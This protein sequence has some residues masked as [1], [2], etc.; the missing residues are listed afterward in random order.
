MRPPEYLR[1]SNGN[2]EA[3]RAIVTE[4]RA[5][6]NMALV[7]DSVLNWPNKFIATA[8]TVDGTTGIMDK[9]T[10]TV[11]YGH[12]AGSIIMIEEFA[13]GYSDLGNVENQ[14]VVLKPSTPWADAVAATVESVGEAVAAAEA[15]IADAI[16]SA[17]TATTAANTAA[18]AA[19]TAA[20]DANTAKT[21]ANTA[22]SA[23]NTAKT[24]A[25]TATTNANTAAAAANTAAGSV[26]TAITNANTAT[27]NANNAATA[28]NTAVNNMFLA[29][30]PVG[31]IFMTVTATNPGT[32][33]GGTWTAFG[34]GRVPVG[35]DT[36]QTEFNTV[37]K[38]GGAKTHT[39]TVNEMPAHNHGV[40]VNQS[41]GGAYAAASYTWGT[42][43]QGFE[44]AGTSNTGGGLAHNNLQPYI[45]C[46]MWKRTA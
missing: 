36:T 19:S 12:R 29:A 46:Y 18:S 35:V 28:A 43:Y 34:A 21:A 2:G 4:D 30:H 22:A 3:V 20:T 14:I 26:N 27:T 17:T 44:A 6:N 39:L 31:S 38:T 9:D 33:Y 13:P 37:E 23:A 16:S 15:D 7:V 40:R 25:D 5:I 41:P 8:G 10:M 24:N 1:G 11:F 45:T 42:A 32:T